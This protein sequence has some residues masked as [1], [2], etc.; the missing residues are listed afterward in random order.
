[1]NQYQLKPHVEVFQMVDGPFANR[2]YEHGLAYRADEIPPEH[3]DRFESLKLQNVPLEP[4]DDFEIDPVDEAV[5]AD[6]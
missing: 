1:M 4:A 3:L 5:E 2:R 6:Q